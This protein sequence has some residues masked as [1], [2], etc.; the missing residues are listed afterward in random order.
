MP[1]H[2]NGGGCYYEACLLLFC[3]ARYRE[4]S[5]V[6]YETFSQ[7][8]AEASLP[9]HPVSGNVYEQT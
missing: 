4:K 5:M 2:A 9:W 8:I 3:Y 1:P 6:K 7:Y